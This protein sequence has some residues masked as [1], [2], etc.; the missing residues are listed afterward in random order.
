M[1]ATVIRNDS[2]LLRGSQSVSRSKKCNSDP[3]R[4][5]KGLGIFLEGNFGYLT[6]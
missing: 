1:S 6:L 5:K 4:E 2:L 3:Q